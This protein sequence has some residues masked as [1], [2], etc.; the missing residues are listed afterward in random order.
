MQC[1]TALIVTRMMR[2]RTIADLPK[3]DRLAQASQVRGKDAA[4]QTVCR[5]WWTRVLALFFHVRTT[6][7]VVSLRMIMSWLEPLPRELLSPVGRMATEASNF[8]SMSVAASGADP[9]PTP[10][11]LRDEFMF[12]ISNVP[13]P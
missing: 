3:G 9:V 8:L 13:L 5:D 2:R 6:V 1:T 12:F 7:H 4:L 10:V 11:A